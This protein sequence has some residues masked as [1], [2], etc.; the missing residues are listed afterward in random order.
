VRLDQIAGATDRML[1]H[2]AVCH[3]DTPL[4]PAF[5]LL[6][7]GDIEMGALA[8]SLHCAKCGAEGVQLTPV[9]DR[10]CLPGD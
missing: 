6:R 1:A 2:C 7:R 10:Y 4:D 8:K 3:A 5:F 9:H